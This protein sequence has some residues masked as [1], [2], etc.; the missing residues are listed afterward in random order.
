M[1]EGPRQ[2]PRRSAAADG[3]GPRALECG[4]KKFGSS[5]AVAFLVVGHAGSRP[6]GLVATVAVVASVRTR[7]SL[8]EAYYC[9]EHGGRIARGFAGYSSCRRDE[10][11]NK[12]RGNSIAAT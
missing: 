6:Q 9:R 11:G 12:K 3:T 7:W 8:I 4:A 1:L 5:D 2:R 10:Q